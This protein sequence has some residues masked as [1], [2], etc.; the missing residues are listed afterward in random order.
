MVKY[1][2]KVKAFLE[3]F[4]QDLLSEYLCFNLNIIN[5]KFHLISFQPHL[6]NHIHYNKLEL[7]AAFPLPDDD[8]DYEY[9]YD[10][11]YVNGVHDI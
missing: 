4:F 6:I 10:Y 11:D 7:L 8:Y 2:S 9:D 1:T 3:L 5:I